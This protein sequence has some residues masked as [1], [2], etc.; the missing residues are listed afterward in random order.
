MRYLWRVAGENR[1]TRDDL[2]MNKGL[3]RW[4][5]LSLFILLTVLVLISLYQLW[6]TMTA[7]V[8][9]EGGCRIEQIDYVLVS[10]NGTCLVP[11]VSGDVSICALPRDI[12]C[13]GA[14][15]QV[16]LVRLLMESR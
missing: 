14:A 1:K 10:G 4:L 3:P 6:L 15:R 16:P 13:E 12:M 5:S 11:V 2:M 7:K 9:I 8:S